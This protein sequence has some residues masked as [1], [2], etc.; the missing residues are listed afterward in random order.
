MNGLGPRNRAAGLL[1]T[2]AILVRLF[3]PG[4]FLDLFYDYDIAATGSVIQKIHPGTYLLTLAALMV[5]TRRGDRAG[6]PLFQAAVALAA[7]T[8]FC[9]TWAIVRSNTAAIG[10]LIDSEFAAAAAC[11]CL[12]RLGEA[13]RQAILPAIVVV[14]V[15]HV[16]I[17]FGETAT[18]LHLFPYRYALA[19]GEITFRPSGLLNHPLN[20]GLFLCTMIPFSMLL[21]VPLL[22]K[23]ALAAVFAAGTFAAESR[24]ASLVAL[25]VGALSYVVATRSDR[26]TGVN[27]ETSRFFQIILGTLVVPFVGVLGVLGGLGERLAKGLNDQSSQARLDAYSLLSYLS[28][29]E[30]FTGIGSARLAV[31]SA[32]RNGL[33]IESPIVVLIFGFGILPTLA[34]F[35]AIGWSM[36]VLLRRSNA[37]CLLGVL[38]FTIVASS[39]NGLASKTPEM[40]LILTLLAASRGRSASGALSQAAIAAVQSAQSSVRRTWRSDPRPQAQLR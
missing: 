5:A 7:M 8:A 15:V 23:L 6:R 19:S 1:V 24:F 30:F 34:F 27:V 3:V 9:I 18:H 31:F 16:L 13:D 10:F 11:F 39:S 2:I 12:S 35:A 36:M 20:S 33:I 40:L 14:M 25:P 22:Q 38:A 17:S 29:S 32:Q 4:G 37:Y 28:P 26:R 21:R